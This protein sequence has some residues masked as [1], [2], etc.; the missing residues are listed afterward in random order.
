MQGLEEFGH[1]KEKPHLF[2]RRAEEVHHDGRRNIKVINRLYE[3]GVHRGGELALRLPIAIE[4]FQKVRAD[5]SN[6][7]T[8]QA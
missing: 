5:S 7:I 4:P 3:Q 2:D 1:R 8:L 6:P